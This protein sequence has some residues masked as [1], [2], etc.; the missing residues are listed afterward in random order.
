MG[1]LGTLAVP[2]CV[3]SS[4]DK[5]SHLSSLVIGESVTASMIVAGFTLL[6]VGGL[7]R[8]EYRRWREQHDPPSRKI[9]ILSHLSLTPAAR[10]MTMGWHTEF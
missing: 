8:K 2:I 6:G 3:Y 4:G 7:V 10:G 1:V 9:K 5:D